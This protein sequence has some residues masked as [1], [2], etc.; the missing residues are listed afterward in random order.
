[1]LPDGASGQEA[2][3]MERS[4]QLRR[5]QLVHHALTKL[6][7][8]ERDI[9]VDRRLSENPS[10]PSELGKRDAVSPERIRQ[11]D[12]R[13]MEKMRLAIGAEASGGGS[14]VTSRNAALLD[15]RAR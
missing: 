13:A 1:V 2:V 8:R 9:V 4:E 6:N 5:H 3:L 15:E 12:M 11:I 14:L 10:S 7:R